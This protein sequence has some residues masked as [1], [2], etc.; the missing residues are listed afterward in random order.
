MLR[1]AAVSR[2]WNGCRDAV[3]ALVTNLQ[4][5]T[6]LKLACAVVR[7]R[8]PAFL[9]SEPG[10]SWPETVLDSIEGE[11][12]VADVPVA[13]YDGPGANNYHAALESLV[14][15]A[16]HVGEPPTLAAM[17][18]N[19]VSEAIMAGM[20]AHWGLQNLDRW[21][22][23]YKQALSGE[24]PEAAD[25]LIG[26]MSDRDIAALERQS[27]MEVADAFG[28]ALLEERRGY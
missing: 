18:V 14:K 9:S 6:A 15:A 12:E 26:M 3:S 5:R 11:R 4:P 13:E 24:A 1:G 2:D 27:W 28:K 21:D 7:R 16:R 20:V 8:L 25:L 23:W 10:V 19:A 22:L 17:V